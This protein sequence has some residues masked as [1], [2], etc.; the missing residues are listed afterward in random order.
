MSLSSTPHPLKTQL[1][2]VLRISLTAMQA[3]ITS[4]INPQKIQSARLKPN[5]VN[6]S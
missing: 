4:R 2:F 5:I 6:S 3:K 1:F